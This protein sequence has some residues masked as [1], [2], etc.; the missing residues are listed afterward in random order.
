VADDPSVELRREGSRMGLWLGDV[1]LARVEAGIP[2]QQLARYVEM[3]LRAG[4]APEA[5]QKMLRG[6]SQV[7]TGSNAPARKSKPAPA[8]PKTPKAPAN[9]E[10]GSVLEGKVGDVKKALGSGDHDASIDALIALEE[11]GKARKGV[12]KA[13][14]ARRGGA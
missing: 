14:A 5:I 6:E 12:L 13:L 9:D 10:L 4:F 11:A 8:K 7:T 2:A 3:Q 1:C